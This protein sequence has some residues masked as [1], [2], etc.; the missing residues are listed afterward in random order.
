MYT[1]GLDLSTVST[2]LVI[3]KRYKSGDK[4]HKAYTFKAKDKDVH[5][6]IYKISKEIKAVLKPIKSS[7]DI[8]IIESVYNIRWNT[9]SLLEVRGAV[10][11]ILK[12]LEIPV[13]MLSASKARFITFAIPK[14][15]RGKPHTREAK[16][17]FV[18][19]LVEKHYNFKF[20]NC[21]ESDA[22]LL[23]MAWAK[24]KEKK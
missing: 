10:I 12:E 19:T 24:S 8:V 23:C 22:A 16:K 20:E 14:A 1:V 2:G 21:D 13:E 9:Q 15:T 18:K 7:I 4:V 6:R 5:D 11:N 17:E 3:V